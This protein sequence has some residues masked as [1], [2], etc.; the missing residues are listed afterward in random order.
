MLASDKAE[1][2]ANFLIGAVNGWEV[3]FAEQQGHTVLYDGAA[4]RIPDTRTALAEWYVFSS[5]ASLLM[6]VIR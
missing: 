5:L 2:G 3:P 4:E 1:D 6:K